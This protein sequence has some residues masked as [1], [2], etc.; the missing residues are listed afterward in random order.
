M[1]EQ[2]IER[3]GACGGTI[4]CKDFII[5]SGQIV[6]LGPSS[7]GVPLQGSQPES[8]VTDTCVFF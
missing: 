8:L 7:S 5:Q 3:G 4:S 2:M 6:F 1:I